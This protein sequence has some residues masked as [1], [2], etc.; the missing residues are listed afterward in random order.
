MFENMFYGE[1]SA[2]SDDD[3]VELRDCN[4]DS[5]LELLRFRYTD[6]V[7][8]NVRNVMRVSVL[9]NRF[10][11]PSLADNCNRFITDNLDASNVS[12]TLPLA[13]NKRRR[14]RSSVVGK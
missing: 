4:N 6:E 11:F 3:S 7:K 8:L 12:N 1:N 10:L 14:T 5:V 13:W 9:A 2:A